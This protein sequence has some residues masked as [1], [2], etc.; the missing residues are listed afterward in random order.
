MSYLCVPA[1]GVGEVM[2]GLLGWRHVLLY[3]VMALGAPPV[4]LTVHLWEEGGW[5]RRGADPDQDDPNQGDQDDGFSP[6]SGV[7]V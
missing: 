5:R 6:G 3:E 2:A 7:G 4:G 1:V